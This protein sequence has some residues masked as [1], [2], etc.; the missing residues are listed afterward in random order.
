MKMKRHFHFKKFIRCCAMIV[1]TIACLACAVALI[2]GDL[3]E[4][5]IV[6]KCSEITVLLIGFIILIYFIVLDY[7]ELEQDG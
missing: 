1:G 5:N 3:P 7:K 4:S 6:I 2:V